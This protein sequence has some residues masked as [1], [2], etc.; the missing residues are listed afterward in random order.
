MMRH[1]HQITVV[2][3]SIA[4][5]GGDEPSRVSAERARVMVVPKSRARA[6]FSALRAVP[7]R[8]SLEVAYCSSGTWQKAVNGVAQREQIDLVHVEHLRGAAVARHLPHP[9]IWDAV[10][11][12]SLVWERA[13]ELGSGMTKLL[14][15][16]EAPRTRRF[17]QIV[18]HEFDAVLVSSPAD[19]QAF[20]DLQPSV[21][22]SVVPNGVDPAYFSAKARYPQAGAVIMTGVMNYPPNVDAAVRFCRDAWPIVASGDSQ[23]L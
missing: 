6:Y 9:K 3:L 17:E 10:D 2:T 8:S 22:T 16:I 13:S 19:Q 23:A 5:I 20:H 12:R 11:S 4:R 15:R 14:G 1:G 7:T 21:R 18:A